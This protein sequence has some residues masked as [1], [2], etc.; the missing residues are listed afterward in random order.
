MKT[1]S[2]TFHAHRLNSI[3]LREVN[4]D[5]PD[6]EES[7]DKR[8]IVRVALQAVNIDINQVHYSYS[9]EAGTASDNRCLLDLSG[10]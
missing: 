2:R 10:T 6:H 3:I 7:D 5:R 1:R 8:F 9:P 4:I